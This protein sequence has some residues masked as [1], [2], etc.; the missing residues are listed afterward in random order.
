LD[1]LFSKIAAGIDVGARSTKAVV[2]REGDLF[3]AALNNG[4][5]AGGAVAERVFQNVLRKADVSAC[6]VE[7]VIATGQGK[8]FVTFASHMELDSVCLAKGIEFFSPSAQTVV[9]IGARKCLAVKCRKGRALGTMANDRCAAGTGLFLEKLADIL[10][11]PLGEMGE[12][13]LK[14]KEQL[15]IVATCGVFI[16]SEVIS[17]IHSKKRPEDILKAIFA[18]I[19]ERI[20]PLLTTLGLEKD[21][22]VAGGVARNRGVVKAME[23]SIGCEIFVPENPEI[24]AALGAALIGKEKVK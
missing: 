22:A 8:Q 15:E 7:H 9:D 16:E 3:S 10:C 11:T 19:A 5:Q 14:S 21:V 4:S 12:L 13:S 17:L 6:D 24:V 23:D 2:L 1:V 20:T 18:G